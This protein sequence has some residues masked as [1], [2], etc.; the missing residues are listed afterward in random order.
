MD[1]GLAR[2]G[3]LLAEERFQGRARA[4]RIAG[5]EGREGGAALGHRALGP[6]R[7]LR[8]VRSVGRGLAAGAGEPVE[9]GADDRLRRGGQGAALEHQGLEQPSRRA[10]ARCGGAFEPFLDA[11]A[12]AGALGE[13]AVEPRRR[14]G[15]AFGPEAAALL[16]R[17]Q[18]L[19]PEFQTGAV[20]GPLRGEPRQQGGAGIGLRDEGGQRRG[21]R[22]WGALGAEQRGG[23]C[24]LPTIGGTFGR[25]HQ[26]TCSRTGCESCAGIA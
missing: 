25:V 14:G 24:R 4:F 9:F 19:R 20:M 1:Q 3:L 15:R 12:R 21:R 23:E 17:R 6:V 2:V 10:R 11:I 26:A 5:A 13:E 8:R 18:R 16:Q 22:G 7:S